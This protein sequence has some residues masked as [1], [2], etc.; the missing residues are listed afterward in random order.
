MS[1]TAKCTRWWLE[2]E[3]GNRESKEQRHSLAK[4]R[5]N[6]Y[7]FYQ[8]GKLSQERRLDGEMRP[9]NFGNSIS[10]V[11]TRHRGWAWVS[12]EGEML[13]RRMFW[14]A[15]LKHGVETT[16]LTCLEQKGIELM[17]NTILSFQSNVFEC[18]TSWMPL[19]WIRCRPLSQCGGKN[20]SV[21]TW[22]CYMFSRTSDE[23][24]SVENIHL[25][26][27]YLSRIFCFL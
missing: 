12:A 3:L 14:K 15:I 6:D 26:F 20:F 18:L 27:F 23:A 16:R 25:R 8:E 7:L 2:E 17:E 13:L 24:F 11:I 21:V 4:Y 5:S 19:P 1:A 22:T 9:G 10:W